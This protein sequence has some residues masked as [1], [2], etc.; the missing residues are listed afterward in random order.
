M[1]KMG[2][3]LFFAGVAGVVGFALMSCGK[4][5]SGPGAGGSE[6]GPLATT[7]AETPASSNPSFGYPVEGEP[8]YFVN[9]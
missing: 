7:A 4:A 3:F 2:T 1:K 9:F 5:P 8:W 6:A